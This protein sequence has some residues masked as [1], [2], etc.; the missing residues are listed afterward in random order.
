MTDH[1]SY[2]IDDLLTLMVCLRDPEFGCDW[3]AIQTEQSIIPHTIEEVYELAEAIRLQDSEETKKELGD[4]LFQ[5]VFLSQIAQD[6]QQF[7]FNDVCDAIVKKMLHRHPHVFPDGSLQSAGTCRAKNLAELGLSWDALKQQEI[8]QQ[9][10]S[11]SDDS[12]G[13]ANWASYLSTVKTAAPAHHVAYDLQK[14]AAKVGFDFETVMDSLDKVKEELEEVEV[15]IDAQ[16]QE[17]LEEELGDLLFSVI[18]VVRKANLKPE[19]VLAKT[20]QK[21]AQ[22]FEKMEKNLQ[23]KHMSLEAA[24]LADMEASW[25]EIK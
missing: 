11:T 2:S 13:S 21:F 9:E 4:L 8:Q 18:N 7:A 1:H 3:D 19:Q 24:T 10:Q 14:Q 5:I 12:S 25:L 15:E 17:A 22:R 16:N 20:N 6:K 23:K